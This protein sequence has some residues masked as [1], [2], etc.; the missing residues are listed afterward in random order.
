MRAPLLIIFLS[1]ALYAGLE[2]KRLYMPSQMPLSVTSDTLRSIDVMP[3]QFIVIHSTANSSCSHKNNTDSYCADAKFHANYMDTTKRKVSWHFTI[4]DKQCVQH[5]RLSQRGLHSGNHSI[6]SRSI[7]IEICENHWKEKKDIII[8]R[9]DSLVH[10]L[11]ITY[12]DL[13]ILYHSECRT[14]DCPR[15]LDS[16][17]KLILKSTLYRWK[18][19]EHQS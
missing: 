3:L 19:K 15:I 13:Q 17:E 7:G 8:N 1:L 9:L 14:K 10:S 12:P 18:K 4:D 5:L 11:Y 2:Y 16:K 6:N